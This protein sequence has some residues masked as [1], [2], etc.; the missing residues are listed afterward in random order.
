MY[1]RAKKN[2]Q[3]TIELVFVPGLPHQNPSIKSNIP[4]HV[5]TYITFLFFVSYNVIID[6]MYYYMYYILLYVYC[7]FYCRCKYT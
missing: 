3:Y 6:Y 7:I 4:F 1:P 5:I 2:K